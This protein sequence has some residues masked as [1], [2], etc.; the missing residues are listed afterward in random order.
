M[1]LVLALDPGLGGAVAWRYVDGF[2]TP[3]SNGYFWSRPG[4][5]IPDIYDTIQEKLAP[6]QRR[7]AFV[8][9]VRPAPHAIQGR[10]GFARGVIAQCK[11]IEHAAIWKALLYAERFSVLEFTPQHWMRGL[12]A[13]PKEYG[14][15]KRKIAAIVRERHP[16]IGKIPIWAADAVALLDFALERVASKGD[17]A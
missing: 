11:L 5:Y 17:A 8:E 4:R 6:D 7:I 14:E 9:R 13:L 1:T 16:E 10:A 3:N 15:R 12:G 2:A